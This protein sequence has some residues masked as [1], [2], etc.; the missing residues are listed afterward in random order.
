MN[1]VRRNTTL[2]LAGVVAC[3]IAMC[4][5]R[6]GLAAEADVSLKTASRVLNNSKNVSEDKVTKVRAVME[7][8][9][10]RPNELARGLKAPNAR[11]RLRCPV[12]AGGRRD[13][14]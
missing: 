12:L 5:N 10:Y 1:F 14:L 8:L 6:I 3:A 11:A 7:R 2:L 4:G 13:L 9:G